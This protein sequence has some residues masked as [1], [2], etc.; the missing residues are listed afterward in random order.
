MRIVQVNIGSLTLFL[1][2]DI[3]MVSEKENGEKE[4][5]L[6]LDASGR[7]TGKGRCHTF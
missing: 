1:K 4:V 5:V 6:K 3:I 2:K 7:K